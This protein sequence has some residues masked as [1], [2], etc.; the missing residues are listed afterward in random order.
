MKIRELLKQDSFIDEI[1]TKFYKN[2]QGSKYDY[3]FEDNFGKDE[4]TIQQLILWGVKFYEK[5]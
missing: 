1:G 3:T 5:I 2:I 4:C